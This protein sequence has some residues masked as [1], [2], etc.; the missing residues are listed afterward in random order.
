MAAVA[1][2]AVEA[3]E[4]PLGRMFAGF[5][6]VRVEVERIVPTNEGIV[7]YIW[8]HGV[9]RDAVEGALESHPALLSACVVDSLDDTHL[10]RLT[11]DPEYR[12][13]L[14]GLQERDV[15]LLSAVGTTDSWTIELRAADREEL[16][17]IQ[18]YFREH[19]V[20]ATLRSIHTLL[21]DEDD[22]RHGLTA[23]Q[24]EA[25]SL[26]HDHGYF[27][28]PRQ[29]TLQ[30]LAEELHISPQAVGSRIQRG[31]DRLLDSALD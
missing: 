3:N 6:G 28:R 15:T 14:T 31:L 19:G 29:V 30:A 1:E 10:C 21:P 24:R 11:W 16:A 12:G 5:P 9:A 25:L 27:K 8:V 20:P 2:F 23:A 22:S 4:F 26:A 18:R 7:P 17:T 13:V